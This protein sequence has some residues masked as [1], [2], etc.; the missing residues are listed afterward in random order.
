MELQLIK[1]EITGI[2]ESHQWLN[3]ANVVLQILL[4]DPI[5]AGLKL[6]NHVVM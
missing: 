3:A 2:G 1:K 6:N 5:E 4:F